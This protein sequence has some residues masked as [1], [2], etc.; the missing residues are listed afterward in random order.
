MGSPEIST[1]R[2]G[3]C[4]PRLLGVLLLLFQLSTLLLITAG[5][6]PPRLVPVSTSTAFCPEAGTDAAGAASITPRSDR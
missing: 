4:R 3:H 5:P 2:G 6:T 1:A